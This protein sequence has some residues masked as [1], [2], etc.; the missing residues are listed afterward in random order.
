MN[1]GKVIK[2]TQE[3]IKK[4]E[5]DPVR[6]SSIIGFVKNYPPT[7][8]L[9]EGKSVLVKGTSDREWIY[10]SSEDKNELKRLILKLKDDDGCFASLEDWMISEVRESREPVWRLEALRYYFPENNFLRENKIEIIPLKTDDA[11]FVVVNSN[12]KQYIGKEYIRER[13]SKSFSAAVFQNGKPAG[14]ALTHDD[15]AIGALHVLDEF[16]KKGFAEEIIINLARKI[17][18]AGGVP[19]AQIEEKNIPAINLFEKIGFVKD[20]RVT[21]LNLKN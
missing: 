1:K 2:Q 18:D 3:V 5:T 6:N 19:I 13:I 14:W 10:I 15:G 9:S 17:R 12:Y 20:R 4:L 16:R 21:W 11:E 8:I 7:I